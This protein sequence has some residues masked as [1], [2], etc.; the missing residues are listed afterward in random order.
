M[1]Y[2]LSGPVTVSG[3]AFHFSNAPYS[4]IEDDLSAVLSPYIPTT[5]EAQQMSAEYS[6]WCK[7]FG[8]VQNRDL[9]DC[10]TNIEMYKTYLLTQLSA[11]ADKFEANLNKEMYF[12][13]SQGFKVNG[14]RRTKDNLQDLV[15]FFDLQAKEGK[16][17]Y[18]DYD[19][20]NRELTKEQVQ[21]LLLEH[22][23][24][25]QALYTQKW[26]KQEAINAAESFDDLRA[27][28]LTFE[29]SD[30]TTKVLNAQSQAG[31]D[32]D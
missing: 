8:Q 19:N 6:R 32:S 29:M 30:F 12:V 18:R 17:E 1:I 21:T 13:S 4:F 28:E 27:V 15:T 24:N 31:N 14:D 11:H 25:G 5:S 3:F 2:K 16:I 23:A 22:V 10:V 7:Q 9:W 26:A 20:V